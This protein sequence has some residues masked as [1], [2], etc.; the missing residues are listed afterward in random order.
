MKRLLFVGSLL[1][2]L[3]LIVGSFLFP[4][5]LI[6]A[7]ASTS[8][9]ANIVRGALAIVLVVVLCTEPPR[10]VTLRLGMGL[11]GGGLL[12]LGLVT[13]F[14][15][16]MH[17]LDAVLYLQLGC[18]LGIEALEF[19]EDELLRQINHFQAV[20]KLQHATQTQQ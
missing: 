7:L 3:A 15:D 8:S 13:S 9:V 10:H 11:L 12:I 18:A 17:L 14:G 6:M 2:V 16:S 4:Q 20:Y 1:C 19:N 5:N